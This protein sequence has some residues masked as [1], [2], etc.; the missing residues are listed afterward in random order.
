MFNKDIENLQIIDDPIYSCGEN[1][2]NGQKS[3]ILDLLILMVYMVFFSI[4][5][6]LTRNATV[7]FILGI[8]FI[9]IIPGYLL[10][11]AMYPKKHTLSLPERVALTLV[12]SF[13]ILPSIGLLLNFTPFGIQQIPVMVSILVISGLLCFVL[14][15][16]RQRIPIEEQF[17]PLHYLG[18]RLKGSV[19]NSDPALPKRYRLVS[20]VLVLVIIIVIIGIFYMM[21]MLVVEDRSTESFTELIILNED[22]EIVEKPLVLVRNETTYFTVIINNHEGS[23]VDYVLRIR[24]VG[25]TDQW[26]LNETPQSTLVE[27]PADIDSD[28]PLSLK[29]NESYQYDFSLD[30]GKSLDK[31]LGIEF[32][33]RG[34]Y[35]MRMELFYGKSTVNVSPDYVVYVIVLV[36]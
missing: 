36:D 4:I 26:I 14:W 7:L 20:N 33:E 9:F 31:K 27:R 29:V 8:P 25:F 2:K 28:L 30:D 23:N 22:K 1:V 15:F 34:N 32:T 5:S 18:D 13:I 19:N 24:A 10:I 3:N 16:Q 21:H 12:L 6:M 35:Q 17:S 11:T